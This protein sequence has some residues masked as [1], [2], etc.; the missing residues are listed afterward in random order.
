MSP[1]RPK[2]GSIRR[3]E[4]ATI[5]RGKSN[6]SEWAS[7]EFFVEKETSLVAKPRKLKKDE[8]DRFSTAME[9]V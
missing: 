3:P 9:V 2:Q 1:S 7:L 4:K 6:H 5:G 8:K